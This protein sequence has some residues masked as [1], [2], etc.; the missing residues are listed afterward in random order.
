MTN[1]RQIIT[2]GSTEACGFA[3]SANA[4]KSLIIPSHT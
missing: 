3:E 1:Q 4:G 2:T